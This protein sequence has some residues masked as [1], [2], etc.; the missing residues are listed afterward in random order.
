MNLPLI[1]KI[2][3]LMV[4][5]R[6]FEEKLIELHPLQEMKSLQHYCI[7]Q[8]AITA[9]INSQLT[10]QDKIFCSYRSHGHY[11]SKG[12]DI[13]KLMQE[14]Y[15]KKNG[16]MGG[17]GGSMHLADLKKGFY[18]SYVI[19]GSYVAIAVGTSLSLKLKKKN[20]I[21]VVFFGDGAMDEGVIYES[22][23]F[24]AIKKLPIVFVCENNGFASLSKNTERQSSI[25]YS[26]KARSFGIKA[27]DVNGQDIIQISK[28]FKKS[29]KFC[30]SG[31]GPVFINAKTY[32]FKS[33]IGVGD[34]IGLGL[35][36]KK[37]LQLQKKSDP[38][39]LAENFL[40]KKKIVDLKSI[41]FFK[42][43]FKNYLNNIVEISRQAPNPTKSDLLKGVFK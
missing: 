38:L 1:K 19:V 16:I 21:V 39:I 43:K 3:F 22:F 15:H 24:A 31:K 27:Y 40:F 33:H 29:K 14:L 34:D 42:N 17:R 25:D 6:M 41:N 11:I 2:F 30:V 37:E 32:R 7:G 20:N 12:C 18:G 26:R 8:E 28:V 13:K 23:N 4:K 9:S 10:D 36:S 35:R 5:I